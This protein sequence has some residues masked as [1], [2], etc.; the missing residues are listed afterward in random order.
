MTVLIGTLYLVIVSVVLCIYRDYDSLK[1]EDV[2]ENN[3][4]VSVLLN[5]YHK[6]CIM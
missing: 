1:K 2:F 4:L 6:A 3:R 5:V